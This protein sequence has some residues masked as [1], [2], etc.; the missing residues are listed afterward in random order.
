MGGY[1][2]N[3]H[4]PFPS[5]PLGVLFIAALLVA[6][7]GAA[8]ADEDKPHKARVVVVTEG[9]PYLEAFFKIDAVR[10][11]A[12]IQYLKPADL[13]D[14]EKYRRPAAAGAFDLVLFDRCA[15]EKPDDLPKAN[16]F[17]IASLP[18]PWKAADMPRVTKPVIK[19]NKDALSEILPN[20]GLTSAEELAKIRIEEGFSFK[21][22]DGMDLP[23]K[24]RLFETDDGGILLFTLKRDGRVDLV[25]TFALVNDKGEL[26]TNWCLRPSFVPFLG[27]VLEKLAGAKVKE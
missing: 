17:F 12:D 22:K 4:V 18:P 21:P 14:K 16:T 3:I 11:A 24:Q 9:N 6:G 5:R 7:G 1:A 23:A 26:N 27:N 2:M 13:A 15:P 19:A 25:L 8:R 10:K 20:V